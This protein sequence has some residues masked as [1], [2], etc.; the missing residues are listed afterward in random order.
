LK[1]ITDEAMQD[2]VEVLYGTE[3]FDS[4][5]SLSFYRT[6]PETVA[7]WAMMHG[8]THILINRQIKLRTRS[9]RELVEFA[10][11]IVDV[12]LDGMSHRLR[13]A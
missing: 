5:D 8:L 12:L 4:R 3:S 10:D 11:Q 7:C 9:R 2:V 1:A 13:Q 6:H